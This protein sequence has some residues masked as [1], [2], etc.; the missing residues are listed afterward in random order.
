MWTDDF[1]TFDDVTLRYVR[2]GGDLPP[3]VLLHGFTDSSAEW[4]RFARSLEAD[5][6]VIMMDERGH[7]L[8]STPPPSSRFRSRRTT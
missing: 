1:F 5:Y 6:D 7:G 2:T 3:L 4:A 8:S